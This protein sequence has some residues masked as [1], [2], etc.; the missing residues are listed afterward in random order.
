MTAYPPSSLLIKELSY[1]D[2]Y[3]DM[4]EISV[5][6]QASVVTCISFFHLDINTGRIQITDLTTS[7][8]NSLRG[9]SSLPPLLQIC[10][11]NFRI[12]T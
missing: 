1:N 7:L 3:N 10:L 9:S 2:N 4:K 12:N 8:Y 11:P 6:L 5:Q